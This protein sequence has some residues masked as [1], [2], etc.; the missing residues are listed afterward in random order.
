M[1]YRH[2]TFTVTNSPH[3]C[4]W[5]GTS[6]GEP[7]GHA[8]ST[9]KDCILAQGSNPQPPCYCAPRKLIYLNLCIFPTLRSFEWAFKNSP[10][11][12]LPHGSAASTWVMNKAVA[13]QNKGT[14]WTSGVRPQ[15]LSPHCTG[16][17]NQLCS[18]FNSRLFNLPCKAISGS[19]T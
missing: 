10:A 16:S 6:C 1:T 8:D 5:K 3:S 9:Q 2:K 12:K 11:L 18:Q 13:K 7:I 19:L 14:Q 15:H 17:D 4:T